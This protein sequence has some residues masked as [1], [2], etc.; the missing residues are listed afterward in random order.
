MTTTHTSAPGNRGA[1]MPSP[2]PQLRQTDDDRLGQMR[3]ASPVIAQAR[4][5]A[6]VALA[7]AERLAAEAQAKL[8]ARE[9]DIEVL[10]SLLHDERDVLGN[11]TWFRQRSVENAAALDALTV[12]QNETAAFFNRFDG[13]TRWHNAVNFGVYLE[14]ESGHIA[15]AVPFLEGKLAALQA[16]RAELQ[17]SLGFAVRG[18]AADGTMAGADEPA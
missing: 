14:A 3:E 15:R 7:E 18:L 13:Q 10:R 9:G 1:E 2:F 6:A 4:A 5:E 17:Q 11:L 12:T 16:R 8:Q